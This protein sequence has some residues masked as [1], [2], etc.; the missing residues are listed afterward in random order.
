MSTQKRP[1]VAAEAILWA[2]HRDEIW[3]GWPAVKA[4]MGNKLMREAAT[5]ANRSFRDHFR[6]ARNPGRR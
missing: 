2:A 1:E 3:V 5:E 6:A 4:I